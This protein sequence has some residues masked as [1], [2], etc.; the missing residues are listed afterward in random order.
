MGFC[1]LGQKVKKIDIGY[2]ENSFEPVNI[3]KK[4]NAEFI[5]IISNIPL[6]ILMKSVKNIWFFLLKEICSQ[7][8]NNNI[9]E[10]SILIKGKLVKFID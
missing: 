10:L 5:V 9:F 7:K 6:K 2:L 1:N 8:L 3:D 4:G